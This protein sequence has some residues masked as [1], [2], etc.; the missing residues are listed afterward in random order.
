MHVFVVTNDFPPRIGGI[1]YYVDQLMR[2]LPAGSATIFASRYRGWEEFDATYPHEVIRLDTEMMLP[3]PSV[4]RRLHQ[5]LRSRQPD[6]VMFGAT[7][8]LGHLGPALR[9][10]LGMRY[11]G[12]TH[13]LELTGALVPGLLKPIGRYASLLTCASDWTRRTLEPKFGR[14]MPVLP[15]GIDAERFHPGVD[16]RTVRERHALGS[17]PVI[18]CVSRLVPR[19]GQDMLIR[20]LPA[21]AREVQDV[22]LLIVGIGPYEQ[23]LKALAQRTG[24]ADRV[25]FAG[26][27]PYEELAA[28]FRAGDVFAMPCRARWFGFD[29]EALG[30]VFLQAAAVGRPVIAGD[31]GGAPETV[32]HGETGLV[33][34]PTRP[35]PLA[36]AL[37]SLLSDP[38]RA[39]A[40]GDAG[41]RWMHTAWTWEH[42]A[43]R[44]TR[45]FEEALDGAG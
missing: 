41:A 35:E 4:E 36:Q 3:L 22:R 24:V 1:N 28:Y 32:R 30:A 8:P 33:V 12:F 7:W 9:R 19:K 25:V 11:G 5:E 40:M 42:M 38:A 37:I 13:G 23:S 43:A 17:A 14:P 34:D 10:R 44:M 31:S 21:V 16:D 27:V 26:A 2:R 29:I 15:S 45:L 20:A 6:L 18:C 39:R